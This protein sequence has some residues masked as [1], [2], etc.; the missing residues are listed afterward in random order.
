MKKI[1]KINKYVERT[2]YRSG[3]FRVTYK[4]HKNT[5]HGQRKGMTHSYIY[6]GKAVA[7]GKPNQGLVIDE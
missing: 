1:R 3:E 5:N 2:A 4:Q 6:L 7:L